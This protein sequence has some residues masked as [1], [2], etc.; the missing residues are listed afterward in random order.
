MIAGTA[1][2]GR[3]GKLHLDDPLRE[4]AASARV[5]EEVALLV[6]LGPSVVEA[7]PAGVENDDVAFLHLQTVGDLL[8]GNNRPVVHLV[9][10]VDDDAFA[11]QSRERHRCDVLAA[12]DDVHLAVEVRAGVQWGL[13]EL[14][15]DAICGV[16]L[17]VT[18]LR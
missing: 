10:Q 2:D 9:R 5:A 13:E 14:G 16:A 12:R 4:V 17:D 1:V 6:L 15:H 3:P 7:V 11:A 18:E 8:G